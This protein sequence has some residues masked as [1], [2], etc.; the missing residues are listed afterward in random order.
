MNSVEIIGLV[1][2]II[3]FSSM[4]TKTT[5]FKGSLIM[6]ILNMI[7]SI[8]FA[9]YGFLRPAYSTGILNVGLI[10][11]NAYHIMLLLKDH[12]KNNN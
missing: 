9:I 12:K 7:G 2:T 1:S 5:S 4:L 3:I 6:R 8:S 11:I 10:F